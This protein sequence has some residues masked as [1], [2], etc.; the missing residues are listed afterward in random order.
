MSARDEMKVELAKYLAKEPNMVQSDRREYLNGVVDRFFDDRSRIHEINRIDLLQI[1]SNGGAHIAKMRL[2]IQISNKDI[3]MNDVRH[4][5]MVESIIGYL[6]K[7]G[8]LV[9]EV[10]FQYTTSEY[11]LEPI[12]D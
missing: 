1:I 6:N 3:E 5:A 9:G 7:H 2:P 8:L 12:E 10:R 4:V 11:D